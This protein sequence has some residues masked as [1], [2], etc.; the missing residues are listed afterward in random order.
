MTHLLCQAKYLLGMNKLNQ[1]ALEE[2]SKKKWPK[3][4]SDSQD[5]EHELPI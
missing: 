2:A 3:N 4:A 5:D 1:Y